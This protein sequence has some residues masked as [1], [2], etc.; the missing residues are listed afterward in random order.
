[1][2][3]LLLFDIRGKMAHFRKFYTS[4]SSLS[5]AFPPRTAITGMLAAFIGRERDTYYEEFN[6][7]SCKIALSIRNPLR[8]TIQ[9]VNYIRT[10]ESDGYATSYGVI[11]RFIERRIVKYPTPLELVIPREFDGEILYRIFLWHSDKEVLDELGLRI[12]ERRSVYPLYFGISELGAIAELIDMLSPENLSE[13]PAGHPLIIH[14]VCRADLI[15]ELLFD[16]G[17][18]PLQYVSEKMPI[19][20][21]RDRAIK[22]NEEFIYG[23]NDCV[24]RA[25]LK[26]PC[27]RVAYVEK[28]VS[29]KENIVFMEHE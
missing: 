5:Y 10:T 6:S 13:L 24:L 16:G 12:R 18:S 19:E 29:I 26:S 17:D 20:F 9:T 21:G 28:G 3:R 22:R 1:M 15:E 23:M 27:T 2:D 8:K 4:S 11:G 7:S 14:T 25:R